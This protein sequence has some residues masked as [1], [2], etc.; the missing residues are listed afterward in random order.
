[1]GGQG[2]DR[3]AERTVGLGQG[4]SKHGVGRVKGGFL[5]LPP[6]FSIVKRN[7]LSSVLFYEA[8]G[9]LIFSKGTNRPVTF[10]GPS[11]PNVPISGKGEARS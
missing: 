7:T 8:E 5:T 4:G 1:M 11:F 6:L 10:L 2:G 9:G 3:K